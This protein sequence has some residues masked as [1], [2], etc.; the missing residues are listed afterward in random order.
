MAVFLY[1]KKKRMHMKDSN[2]YLGYIINSNTT[3]VTVVLPEKP[4]GKLK[5]KLPQGEKLV[6]YDCYDSYELLAFEIDFDETGNILQWKI[7]NA[8]K[9]TE[10]RFMVAIFAD[11]RILADDAKCYKL[12]DHKLL[13]KDYHSHFEYLNMPKLIDQPE[14]TKLFIHSG[15]IYGTEGVRK[16][17][18]NSWEIEDILAVYLNN[19]DRYIVDNLGLKSEGSNVLDKLNTF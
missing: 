10:E 1:C 2:I 19:Y 5:H 13:Q 3:T 18:S 8:A 4:F 6:H 16:Y 11:G 14:R 9:Y 12:W 7:R 17:G 15:I